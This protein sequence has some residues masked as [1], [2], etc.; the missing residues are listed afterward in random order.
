MRAVQEL[1]EKFG[2]KAARNDGVLRFEVT[3]G[4]AFIPQ[5]VTELSMP[6]T[7]VSVRRPSLDDVFLK[8]TGHE[9]RDESAGA[10]DQ[11]RRMMR[12]R[13]R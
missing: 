8:I 5:L 4:E 13:G 6:T 9:I 3:D 10:G 1:H 11:M 7:S 2:I 12:M